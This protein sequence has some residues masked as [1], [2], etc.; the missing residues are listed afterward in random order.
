MV[1]CQVM[2][3][4]VGL[5]ALGGLSSVSFG[6]MNLNLNN[7]YQSAN[8]PGSG[9][10]FVTFSGTVDILNPF[11]DVSGATIEGASDG[12]N[13]LN[14]AFDAAFLSYVLGNNPGLDYT[15]DIFT[16]EVTSTTPL[17]NYWLGPGGLSG[18]AEFTA[19]ATGP[20]LDAVDNELFGVT[21]V[22]EPATLAALGIG[23]AALIRRRRKSK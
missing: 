20:S 14:M 9:S 5:I 11:Y 1:W 6:F 17:G 15:G 21:V 10:I 18:L 23:A 16:A 7:P 2:K 3:K 22:P 19:I 4:L 12:T 13:F 8:V